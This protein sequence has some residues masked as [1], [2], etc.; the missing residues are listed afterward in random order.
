MQRHRRSRLSDSHHERNRPSKQDLLHPKKVG[1]LPVSDQ[2]VKRT[3]EIKTAIPLLDAIDI[4]GKEITSDALLT[5]HKIADYLVR[6]RKAHYH[7]T[8]KNNQPG[9]F[10]DIELYFKDRQDPDFVHCEPPDHARIEIRKIWTTTELNS[11]LNFPHVGQAFV[12]QRESTDKKSGEYSCEIAYGI[13]SRTPEQ[14]DPKSVLATN[15]G[16]WSIENSCHYIID[17]NYDED[18]SRIRTGHGPENI[19]RLRRFAISIIKS[20]GVRSVAQK[21][22]QLTRNVRSVFDYLR[23]TENSCACALR[24]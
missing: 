7:F 11:Y 6:D 13:T 24:D 12:I 15:R 2:E 3:N 17:W 9:L 14:A 21:M 5:Q 4:Q 19:A 8:V 18:R 20:K 22:R 23:M 1:A 10:Q 16:H